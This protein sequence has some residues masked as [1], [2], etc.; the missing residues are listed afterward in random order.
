MVTGFGLRDSI[1]DVVAIQ[2]DK[3]WDYQSIVVRDSEE[4]VTD[5]LKE[6]KHYRD[7]LAISQEMM[8]VKKKGLTNQEVYVTVPKRW[9]SYR[10]L[11]CLINENQETFSNWVMKG[12]S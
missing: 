10:I 3:L 4:K 5:L 11:Y 1:T 7:D 6:S 9:I 12:H 8:T 2:F